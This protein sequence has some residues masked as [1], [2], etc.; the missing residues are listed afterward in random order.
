MS[1]SVSRLRNLFPRIVLFVCAWQLSTYISRARDSTLSRLRIDTTVVRFSSNVLQWGVAALT[2]ANVANIFG[3]SRGLGERSGGWESTIA[4]L[5][6][7][8]A[9]QSTLAN[10]VSGLILMFTRPFQVGD[11]IRVADTE[12]WVIEIGTFFTHINSMTHT[13]IAIPNQKILSGATT[14]IQ[15]FS[16]LTAL[17][18]DCTIST[19][20]KCDI[21]RVRT[22]LLSAMKELHQEYH[23]KET[24]IRKAELKKSQDLVRGGLHRSYSDL[25]VDDEDRGRGNDRLWWRT[26]FG[27]RDGPGRPLEAV[28]DPSVLLLRI[29]DYALVWTIRVWCRGRHRKWMRDAVHSKAAQALRDANIPLPPLSV[30]FDSK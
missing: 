17:S 28:A 16:K 30:G 29:T 18:V 12:G 6:V 9:S 15:N 27:G 24:K 10:F 26:E 23:E 3:Y 20:R 11:H 5:A 25:G 22:V 4:S 8:L 2:L 13:R 1:S 19:H 14:T 7:G 21:E